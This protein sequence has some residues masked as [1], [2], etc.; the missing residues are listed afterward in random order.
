MNGDLIDIIVL[1]YNQ[2]ELTRKCITSLNS[3]R[4]EN[5]RIIYVD[6]GSDIH[7]NMP[8]YPS[9]SVARLDRNY[10][11]ARGMNAGLS[12]IRPRADVI[13]I[14]N[15]CEVDK[16]FIKKIRKSRDTIYRHSNVGVVVPMTE[17]C[18]REI[19]CR[20]KQAHR[21]EPYKLEEPIPAVCWYIL[22]Y[23]L[24]H[25]GKF[26][27]R[28]EIGWGE[29]FDFC[30]E[31]SAA[32]YEMWAVPTIFVRHVGSQTIK[33]MPDNGFRQRNSEYYQRKWG[34]QL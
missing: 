21:H 7:G 17:K 18:C 22:R 12:L 11:F 27:S 8:L 3:A 26:D 30:N 14:N 20:N 32:G 6:N 2:P 5:E 4:S 28:Y 23:A 34:L 33:D 24:D 10:G 9:D 15:D 19:I 16:D 25:I 13:I 1:N 31:M 29:D